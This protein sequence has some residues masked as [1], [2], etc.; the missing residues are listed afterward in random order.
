M[1]NDKKCQVFGVGTVCLKLDTGYV[2]TLNDERHEKSQEM[3]GKAQENPRSAS[4]TSNDDALVGSI[5]GKVGVQH[6]KTIY[7]F[8]CQRD[9]NDLYT[10]NSLNFHRI[11]VKRNNDAKLGLIPDPSNCIPA[12]RQQN[13]RHGF[14]EHNYG[15]LYMNVL[16]DSNQLCCSNVINAPS[17]APNEEFECN[18]IFPRQKD[19][20]VGPKKEFECRE[21][22]KTIVLHFCTLQKVGSFRPHRQEDVCRMITEISKHPQKTRQMKNPFILKEPFDQATHKEAPTEHEE[23]IR[24]VKGRSTKELTQICSNNQSI[25]S[26]LEQQRLYLWSSL[27][28]TAI[29][30]PSASSKAHSNTIY[31]GAPTKNKDSGGHCFMRRPHGGTVWG[32]FQG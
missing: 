26:A 20:T 23:V 8:K 29:S 15:M 27:S 32:P 22:R 2:L 12:N 18:L 11:V 28:S 25:S 7:S 21:M 3:T 17:L 31:D 6:F 14:T 24:Q 19:A 10:V 30:K 16:Y 13:Q 9:G 5:E 1:A 4:C